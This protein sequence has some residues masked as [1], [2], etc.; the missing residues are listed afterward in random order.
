VW[1]ERVEAWWTDL[2]NI[3][4]KYHFKVIFEINMIAGYANVIVF[5]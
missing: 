1:Y 4:L 5:K 3:C 2:L